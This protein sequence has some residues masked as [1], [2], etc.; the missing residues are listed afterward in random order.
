[1]VPETHTRALAGL[2]ALTPTRSQAGRRVCLCADTMET[3][4]QGPWGAHHP[5]CPLWGQQGQMCRPALSEG[6]AQC[7]PGREAGRVTVVPTGILRSPYEQ[8]RTWK[9]RGSGKVAG[10]G[11]AREEELWGP[12]R[13]SGPGC[14]SSGGTCRCLWVT[15]HSDRGLG[16]HSQWTS[17]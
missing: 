11:V 7:V 13:G 16:F 2:G 14:R 9:C 15:V 5:Q 6:W 4:R 12:W 8:Q 17:G 1:M 3:G 10:G